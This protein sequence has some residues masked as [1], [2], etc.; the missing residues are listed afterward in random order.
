MHSSLTKLFRKKGI[1]SLDTLTEEERDVYNNYEKTL[2]K[3]ELTIDDLR[4]FLKQQIDIIESKWSDYTLVQAKK[5]EFIP[6]HTVYKTL[7]RAIDAPQV[8]KES[9]EKYLTQLIK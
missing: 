7:L 9:L 6:Y 5:S 2:S 1:E 8:E 4:M 3:E